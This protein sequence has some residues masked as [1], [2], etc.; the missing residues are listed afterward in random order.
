MT[1]IK[2]L[3]KAISLIIQKPY[4]LNKVIENDKQ[5]EQQLSSKHQVNNGLP[6]LDLLDIDPNFN[7]ELNYFTFLGGGSLPTDIALLKNLSKRF[8]NCNYFEIGT[9]RGES[10][11]HLAD[12]CDK[13]YTLNLS[14]KE[15]K[16]MGMPPAYAQLHGVLSKP[17]PKITHLQGNSLHYD[18]AGLNQKFD[19]IF[20]DGD[21][22]Y[23][24]VKSDTLNVVQ[25]L[26][27]DDS[28]IVWHDAAFNPEKQRPE[29]MLGILDGTPK[30]MHKHIYHVSN[31]MCAVY[32]KGVFNKK[33]LETPVKP[34]VLFKIDLSAQKIN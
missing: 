24:T 19:L 23:P 30:E 1:K 9:W 13:C 33:V 29:V 21:H 34:E 14:E 17:N 20:I 10:C 4:L 8:E 27:H 6:V 25:H 28:I 7:E 18:F 2:K 3:L 31:T 32:I 5:W 12:S 11:I 16:E 22:H 15:M 26:M